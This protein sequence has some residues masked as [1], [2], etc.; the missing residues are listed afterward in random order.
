[1]S[2][3]DLI[4]ILLVSIITYGI[5]ILFIASDRPIRLNPYLKATLDHIPVACFSA[6]I[7]PWVWVINGEFEVDIA[8]TIAITIAAITGFYIRSLYTAI[9]TG[10]IALWLSR[11]LLS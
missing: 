8:R 11:Y 4:L 7:F 1:M 3:L 5:R 6:L 10:L 2:L 9:I